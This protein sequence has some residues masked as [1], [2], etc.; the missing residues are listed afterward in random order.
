MKIS[1]KWLHD[2]VDV[3][4]YFRKPQDLAEILTQA[5]LE[6]EEIKDRGRD[7][8]HVVIGVILEKAQHPNA[9]KLSLCRVAT[10]EGVV[11]QIVCGAK[12]HKAN[13]RV[14]VALPGAVLPGNFAIKVSSLRGIESGGM[15]CSFKEL[16]LPEQGD[17]IIILPTEA[18]IGQAY[19]TWAG[20]DDITFELKVTPNRADCLSHYG[21]AREV[22][23]L[24][25]KELKAVQ[26]IFKMSTE[27]TQKRIK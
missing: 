9:D 21:L 20:L 19:A 24:L 15:L 2:F 5:G 7:L 18:P 10:G 16:G 17:G 3:K 25:K 26:P 4:E 27:S 14:V 22:A 1:L 6:V 8:N 12:N 11:H 13:D 23:C